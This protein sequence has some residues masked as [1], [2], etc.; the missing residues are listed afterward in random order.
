MEE[1]LK[2]HKLLEEE[3]NKHGQKMMAKAVQLSCYIPG[4]TENNSLLDHGVMDGLDEDLGGT[5]DDHHPL[6]KAMSKYVLPMIQNNKEIKVWSSKQ[7]YQ[8]MGNVFDGG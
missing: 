5:M 8:L 4:I 2:L 7:L 3:E 1:E 6:M